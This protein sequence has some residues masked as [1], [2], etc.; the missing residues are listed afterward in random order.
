MNACQEPR[1]DAHTRPST[2]MSLS[3]LSG[4]RMWMAS[5]EAVTSIGGRVSDRPSSLHAPSHESCYKSM[6]HGVQNCYTLHSV[7]M[8]TSAYSLGTQS[9]AL[10]ASSANGANVCDSRQS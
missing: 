9:L 4:C 10:H 2:I 6:F 1:G 7:E 8:H 5:T 3:M